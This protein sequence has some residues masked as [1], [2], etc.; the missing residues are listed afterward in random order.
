MSEFQPDFLS[1]DAAP[2]PETEAGFAGDDPAPGFFPARPPEPVRGRPFQRGRSGNPAGR[3]LGSR[4]RRT[5]MMELLTDAELGDLKDKAVELGRAG[6]ALVLRAWIDKLVPPVRERFLEFA[7]P[8]IETPADLAPALG[9]VM[10]A[11]AAGEISPGEAERITN[12]ALNWMHAIEIAD[13]AVQLQEMKD[14]LK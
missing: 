2:E 3:P 10:A 14:S 9:A 4:N 13:L 8:P 7:L 5:V 12:S 6:N 11:L 1:P